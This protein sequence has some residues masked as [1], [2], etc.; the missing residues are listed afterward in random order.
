MVGLGPRL[1]PKGEKEGAAERPN[2]SH[3]LCEQGKAGGVENRGQ[4]AQKK[5]LMLR[6]SPP[7][8]TISDWELSC[9]VIWQNGHW[10]FCCLGLQARSM[11]KRSFHHTRIFLA[12]L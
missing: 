4:A 11:P 3:A 2:S 6:C 12:I 8:S 7:P 9:H 5:Y 1:P 10:R